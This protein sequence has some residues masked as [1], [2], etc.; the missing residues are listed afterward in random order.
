M[1]KV[2]VDIY[3]KTY[4]HCSNCVAMSEVFTDWVTDTSD[5]VKT[6]TLSAEDHAEELKDLGARSAPVYVVKRDGNTTVVSGNNPDILVDALNGDDGIW[7]DLDS[8]CSL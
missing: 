3:N 1:S 7:D 6:F 8:D 4:S 5:R 2:E